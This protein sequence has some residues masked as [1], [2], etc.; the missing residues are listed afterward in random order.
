M[1]R[2]HGTSLSRKEVKNE[3]KPENK[4]KDYCVTKEL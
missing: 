2:W 3:N 1:S 4:H